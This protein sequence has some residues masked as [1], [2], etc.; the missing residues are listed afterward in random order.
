MLLTPKGEFCSRKVELKHAAESLVI[1]GTDRFAV[2]GK[3]FSPKPQRKR[4]VHTSASMSVTISPDRSI[5]GVTSF[6]GGA[7]PPGKMYFCSHCD[8]VFGPSLLPI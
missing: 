1:K 5:A 4:I 2:G 8:V 3:A 6:S 7:Y